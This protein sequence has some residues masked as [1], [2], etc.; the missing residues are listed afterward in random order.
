M[1]HKSQFKSGKG[2]AGFLRIA[3]A[4]RFFGFKS[5]KAI[6]QAMKTGRLAYYK[7]GRS[8]FIKPEDLQ[9]AM[10]RVSSRREI[11]G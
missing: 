7:F 1:I 4:A 5:E 6:R 9:A 2:D 11:V 3:D 8:I 10:S